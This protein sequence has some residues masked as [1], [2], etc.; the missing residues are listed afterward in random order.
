VLLALLVPSTAAAQ[1]DPLGCG[2]VLQRY[3]AVLAVVQDGWKVT[4]VAERL[5]VFRQSVH[6]RIA[7]YERGRSGRARGPM[8][9]TERLPPPDLGRDRGAD[10]RAPPRAPGLGTPPDRASAGSCWA[11]PR[12]LPLGHLPVPQNGTP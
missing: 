3:Q 5:G 12:A 4:E 10:V 2:A 1:H 6:A 8:A 9:S 7:R 11:G